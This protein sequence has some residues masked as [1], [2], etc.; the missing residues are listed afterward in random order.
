MCDKK[1]IR[2]A[3]RSEKELRKAAQEA[4]DKKYSVTSGDRS[5]GNK[6]RTAIASCG[7]FAEHSFTAKGDQP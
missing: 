5:T 7:T 6:A 4:W 2:P 1:S 3:P